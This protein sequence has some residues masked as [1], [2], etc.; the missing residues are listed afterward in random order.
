ME[1]IM[2][3]RISKLI[4]AWEEQALF[5]IE[6]FPVRRRGSSLNPAEFA[7]LEKDLFI[8]IGIYKCAMEAK[9]VLSSPELSPSTNP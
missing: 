1:T 7:A 4:E 8:A 3:D 9:R 5:T 2:K 6:R